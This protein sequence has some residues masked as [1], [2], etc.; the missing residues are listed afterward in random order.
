M[1][2]L[3]T[4]IV[5]SLLVSTFR[6]NSNLWRQKI[7]FFP[8]D[9]RRTVGDIHRTASEMLGWFT[10]KSR[11]F[12][13]ASQLS[14]WMNMLWRNFLPIILTS[15]RWELHLIC[16]AIRQSALFLNFL[17]SPS[18]C[19]F[20]TRRMKVDLSRLCRSLG[21]FYP[22]IHEVN[23]WQVYPVSHP[24]SFFYEDKL[25]IQDSCSA[26]TPNVPKAGNQH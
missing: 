9:F 24:L 22:E 25:S 26:E 8:L 15:F 5:N 16:T 10:F 21:I 4:T 20:N 19:L 17:K 14:T 7:N 13:L 11:F 1:Y 23:L 2:S 18:S 12:H 6:G 3:D